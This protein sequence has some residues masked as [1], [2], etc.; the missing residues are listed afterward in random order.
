MSV[1]HCSCVDLA[2]PCDL[3]TDAA[4]LF[5]KSL[6]T[7]VSLV[8]INCTCINGQRKTSDR[9][10][11]NYFSISK[12]RHGNVKKIK[13][14]VKLV[15]KILKTVRTTYFFSLVTQSCKI[16]WWK[17]NIRENWLSWVQWFP[18]G[19][20]LDSLSTKRYLPKTQT[21]GNLEIWANCW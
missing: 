13:E 6:T 19:Q 14:S 21:Q 8:W 1:K 3:V 16:F 7:C 11:T 10:L 2:M 18:G 4:P 12:R 17:I 20:T 15:E 9:M 5:W